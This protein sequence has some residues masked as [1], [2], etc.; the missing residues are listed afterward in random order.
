MGL[1][2]ASYGSYTAFTDGMSILCVN[3]KEVVGSDNSFR[4][5]IEPNEKTNEGIFDTYQHVLVVPTD[6][7]ANFADTITYPYH[8]G[9]QLV[10]FDALTYG[11]Y[12]V[13]NQG[14]VLLYT[15]IEPV[16]CEQYEI[17]DNITY[18]KEFGSVV[19]KEKTYVK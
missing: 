9:Y 5:P 7:E 8:D 1:S 2:I 10:G 6:E 12:T 19:D 16:I 4:I 13:F 15:N 17:K 3:Y 14:S 11:K 18:S